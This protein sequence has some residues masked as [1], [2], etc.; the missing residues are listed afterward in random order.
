MIF[1]YHNHNLP[2]SSI[3]KKIFLQPG[4]TKT[5]ALEASVGQTAAWKQRH[6]TVVWSPYSV[7]YSWPSVMMTSRQSDQTSIPVRILRG[8]GRRTVFCQY[9]SS[10]NPTQLLPT[11]SWEI[12]II[13]ITSQKVCIILFWKRGNQISAVVRPNF[14]LPLHNNPL[15]LYNTL[16]GRLYTTHLS[17]CITIFHL[18][19]HRNITKRSQHTKHPM[20]KALLVFQRLRSPCLKASG[21]RVMF[22][23]GRGI[24]QKHIT[25]SPLSFITCLRSPR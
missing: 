3:R 17:C 18:T 21:D 4:L 16:F 13:R 23:S 2:E 19:L 22:T 6:S 10:A 8:V 9:I 1:T 25:F 15:S 5:F 11:K 12:E 20:S 24:S 14:H 7:S